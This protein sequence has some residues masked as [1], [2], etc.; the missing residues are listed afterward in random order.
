M[1]A[2]MMRDTALT[3]SASLAMHM[4]MARRRRQKVVTVSLLLTSLSFAAVVRTPRSN[5]WTWEG[6]QV[7]LREGGQVAL[8]E[9]GQHV[10]CRVVGGT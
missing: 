7:A 5:G 4:M 10:G 8:R 2:V 1:L 3:V 6:G 9:G